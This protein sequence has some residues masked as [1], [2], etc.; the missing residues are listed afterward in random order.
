M[1]EYDEY[2]E[3]QPYEEQ[4]EQQYDQNTIPDAPPAHWTNLWEL[5]EAVSASGNSKGL[6]W[7]SEWLG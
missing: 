1:S 5:Y 2:G 4:Y 3:Y 6:H 7:C